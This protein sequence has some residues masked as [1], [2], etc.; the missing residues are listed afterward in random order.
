LTVALVACGGTDEGRP[1]E[2]LGGLV[3]A[4]D[5]AAK[6][7]D[8]GK[9]TKDV[10][11]LARALAMPHEQ[12][13]TLLGPHRL[14]GATRI[15]VR[16]GDKVVEELTEETAV[17]LDAK[18]N[19]HALA[20]NSKE[21]GREIFF[22]DGWMY[23]RP[24]YGKYHKRRPADEAEPARVRGEIAASAAAAFELVAR[25][26]ALSDGG[27]VDADGKK[28]RKIVIATGKSQP[29]SEDEPSTQRSWREQ[30]VVQEVS[31]EV[32][33]DAATGT[34]LRAR[35]KGAVAFQREGHSFVMKV[36][37]QHELGAFGKVTQVTPPP[38]QETVSNIEQPHEL[39]ERE[40][41]LQG[42]APPSRRAPTP[43]VTPK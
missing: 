34:P 24:R 30:A 23:L 9:A 5:S 42:I 15:E 32:L 38:D 19:Y 27:E 22:V 33:L 11:E 2:D 1:D 16:E 14:S 36:E 18:G 43:S 3:V 6:A 37:V 39:D 8:V 35:V 12:V 7:I 29:S 21:Y 20:A 13:G 4:G 10:R 17:E 31:G 40:S 26:A 41:L 25:G 28:A